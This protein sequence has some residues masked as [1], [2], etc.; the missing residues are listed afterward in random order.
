MKILPSLLLLFVCGPL[1]CE[2]N[3]LLGYKLD[4]SNSKGNATCLERLKKKKRDFHGVSIRFT[5]TQNRLVVSR[6]ALQPEIY[7]SYQRDMM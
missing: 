3:S 5:R 7:T 6:N 4:W 2:E 1:L